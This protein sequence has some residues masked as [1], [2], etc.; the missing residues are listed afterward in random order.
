MYDDG[1][2]IRN[3]LHVANHCRGI[4]A[5]LNRSGDGEVHDIGGRSGCENIHLVR[6]LCLL[7]DEQLATSPSH[8]ARY[9]QSALAGEV[10]VSA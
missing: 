4:D 7:I 2:D 1:R 5:V 10:R 8:R 6:L 9:P 3:W